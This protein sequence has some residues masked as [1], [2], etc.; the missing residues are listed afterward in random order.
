VR[1]ALDV[2]FSQFS[3]GIVFQFACCNYLDHGRIISYYSAL[4]KFIAPASVCTVMDVSRETS[5]GRISGTELC[6]T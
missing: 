1:Y 3:I 2:F 6:F 5:I 4:V